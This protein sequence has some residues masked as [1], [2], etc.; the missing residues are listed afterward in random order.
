M[1]TRTGEELGGPSV[2]RSLCSGAA[3][4]AAASAWGS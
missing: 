4:F 1:F 3:L 2:L